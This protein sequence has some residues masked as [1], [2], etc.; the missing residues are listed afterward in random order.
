MAR[1]MPMPPDS[2]LPDGPVP[3]RRRGAAPLLPG[4]GLPY[5]APGEPGD[6]EPR[7]PAASQPGGDLPGGLTLSPGLTAPGEWQAPCALPGLPLPNDVHAIAGRACTT[8]PRQ[9][10]QVNI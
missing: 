2:E 7:G 10:E 3:G 4:G 5:G 1:I 8:P 6:P 9:R